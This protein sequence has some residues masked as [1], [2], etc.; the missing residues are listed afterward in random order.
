[1]IS[2]A[3]L[4][5][6]QSIDWTSRRSSD[7]HCDLLCEIV[8]RV[9]EPARWETL[10]RVGPDVRRKI[11]AALA[12]VRPELNLPKRD[13]VSAEYPAVGREIAARLVLGLP[14]GE[15]LTRAE[16]HVWLTEG[17]SVDPIAWLLRGTGLEARSV[18][19]ARWLLRVCADSEMR[20]AL[21]R[22]RREGRLSEHTIDLLPEDCAGG[23]NEAW[24]RRRERMDVAEFGAEELAHAPRWLRGLGG[25]VRVLTTAPALAREGSEMSHCVG[26]YAGAV[27][28]GRSVIVSVRAWGHR[29]TVEFEPI[30]RQIVQAKGPRNQTPS[31]IVMLLARRAVYDRE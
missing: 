30:S 18:E 14:V 4:E 25:R 21:Y 27:R 15:G 23:P 11:L 31:P 9:F 7:E 1:M 24:A 16:R 10:A 19:V 5:R 8:V 20:E 12:V 3:A 6:W 2:G 26:G 29:G 17:A 13:V 22:L 28:D